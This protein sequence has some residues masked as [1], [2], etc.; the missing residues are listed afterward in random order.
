MGAY[1]GRD[2]VV[3]FAIADENAVPSGLTYK[4]LGMMRGK[5][6]KAS[7]DTVDTTADQSPSFTKTNLVTFK[8]AEFSGDGVTYTDAVFNQKELKAHVISPGAAT[9]NQPKVWF[10]IIYPDGSKYEGPFIV[11]EWSD[12]S[13][14]SDAATWSISAMSN[15]AVNFTA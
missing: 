2:V 4:R 6:M 11:T 8:S 1:T 13:P 7:W 12:D 3:N 10:Q 15:G 9:A 5:G 14:Y